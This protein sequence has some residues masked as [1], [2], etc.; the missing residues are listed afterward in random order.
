MRCLPIYFFL[1]SGGIYL[2]FINFFTDISAAYSTID[3]SIK[4]N[5][6]LQAVHSVTYLQHTENCFRILHILSLLPL[7]V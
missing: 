2:Y 7:H 1:I 3:L 5:R 4:E 6:S